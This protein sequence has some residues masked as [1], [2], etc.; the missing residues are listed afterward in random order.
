MYVAT[1]VIVG[2]IAGWI[3]G[4]TLTVVAPMPV[5]DIVMG[6]AGGVVGGFLVRFTGHGEYRTSIV[7]ATLV[8]GLLTAATTYVTGRRRYA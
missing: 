2:T 7:A 4:R 5:L 8:A 1:W 6:V 3:T